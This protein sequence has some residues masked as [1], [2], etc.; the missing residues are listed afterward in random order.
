MNGC[1]MKQQITFFIK[2]PKNETLMATTFLHHQSDICTSIFS[3]SFKS[4]IWLSV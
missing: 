4:S 3:S 2:V 1:L